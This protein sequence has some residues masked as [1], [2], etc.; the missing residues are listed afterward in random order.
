MENKW[1]RIF[2]DVGFDYWFLSDEFGRMYS[3]EKKMSGLVQFFSILAIFISCL[4]LYGL[5]SYIAEQKTKEIGVRKILGA[6]LAEILK[7]LVSD[8]I[9]MIGIA[10]LVAFPIGYWLMDNWLTNFAYNVGISWIIFVVTAI[11]ILMLTLI[12]VSYETLKAAMSQPV[13]SLRHE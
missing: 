2:P 3:T 8:F 10:C 9:L 7:I 12:T 5:A 1:K 11:V 6:S 13:K 4:G